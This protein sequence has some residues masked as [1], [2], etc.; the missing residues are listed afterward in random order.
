MFRWSN[1]PFDKASD[2]NE[3]VICYQGAN[4]ESALTAKLLSVAGVQKSHT[5]PYHPMG[6]GSCERINRTLGNMIRVLPTRAK[7]IWPQALKSLT[8]EYNCTIHE[9][10][11]FA[12][13]LLMFGRT[14]RLPV[15]IVFGS[16]I[17]NPEVVD[18]D[19]FVQSLRRDPKEAM[20]TAQA[21]A[22]TQLSR[23][24]DL[25]DR[26]VRGAP[27]EIGYRV[28]LANK[29]EC[30]KRKL[31]DRWE[32]TVYLV[33]GLNADSHA[34]KIQNTSTGQ[35]KKVHRNV[36]M[37]VN[38]LPLPY[39]A[40]DDGTDMSG[41]TE[42]EDM[43]DGLVVSVAMDTAVD[44]DAEYRTK[45]WVLELPSEGTGDTS[46]EGDVQ[47]LDAQD[48]P[49]LVSVEDVL[50]L[51]ET[52]SRVLLQRLDGP[53]LGN[54][55]QSSQLPSPR[56]WGKGPERAEADPGRGGR[57][58]GGPTPGE[59]C[60]PP[61]TATRGRQYIHPAP[62][63]RDM[64]ERARDLRQ[65]QG[66]GLTPAQG[67]QGDPLHPPSSLQRAREGWGQP[68]ERDADPTMAKRGCHY[69]QPAPCTREMGERARE[70]WGVPRRGGP[71]PC[72]RPPGG[73][74]TSTLLSSPG[75]EGGDSQRG[76]DKPGGGHR[77]EGPSPARGHQWVNLV[78]PR[79]GW[80]RPRDSEPTPGQGVRPPPR[81]PNILSGISP[82][83]RG[84]PQLEVTF[85]IDTNGILNISAVSKGKE[86]KITITNDKGRLSKE[87][88]ERMLQDAN[89][90]KAE[91][92]AQR[93]KI[94]AKNSLES[95]TFNM[96]SSVEDDNLKGKISEEDKKKLVGRC[97]Q[98]IFWLENNKGARASFIITKLYQQGGMNTDTV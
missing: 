9:T 71:T 39:A 57:R 32:D 93:E 98:A 22:A 53:T 20:N 15:D 23:H 60:L 18:Y 59:E 36:I 29:G 13:F 43:N 87:D 61:P 49:P 90:Y 31:A 24:A 72:P 88:I 41:L 56:I 30:G 25:Y 14:P 51:E 50:Q 52:L 28:L 1:H 95:Y 79:E 38:F 65:T 62:F 66:G 27:L 44:D 10:T 16:V 26:R 81:K 33:T 74:T 67:H 55:G 70:G 2:Y 34:F 6:N 63:P 76:M 35:E 58:E 47:S 78:A 80:S 69:I 12:P 85:D 89:K 4:F 68:L 91:D 73:A 45:V 83:P 82:A 86:N 92:N 11:G 5:T 64:G 40:V 42:S 97:N 84:I 48:I 46:L 3:V 7:H 94:A 8:F 75:R 54:G 17:E 96:K 37:P 77:R 19:Q 21:S